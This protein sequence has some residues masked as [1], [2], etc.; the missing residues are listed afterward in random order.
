ME[1]C[2]GVWRCEDVQGRMGVCEGIHDINVCMNVRV[3]MCEE[4]SCMY[5]RATCISSNM[6]TP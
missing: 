5:E 1:E 4:A 3:Y 6:C 2:G